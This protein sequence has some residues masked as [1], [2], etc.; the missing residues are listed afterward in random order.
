MRTSSRPV[1]LLL[2]EEVELLDVAGPAQA[3][4]LAG[5]Q[6]NWRPFKLF[7]VSAAPG[8]ISTRGQIDILAGVAFADCPDPEIIIVPGGYG[9][10]RALDDEMLVEWLREKGAQADL[11]A[12]VG[13]GALLLGKAGLLGDTEVS[14]PADAVELV[15]ELAPEARPD[16][17]RT[18][19][20]SGKIISARGGGAAIQLGLGIV[21]RSLGPKQVSI[22][23]DQLAI[24][25][26]AAQPVRMRIDIPES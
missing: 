16:P 9:A 11:L 19:I 20:D 26:E 10:R 7:A 8:P 14:V 13:Y 17:S 25:W 4:S 21:G 5:R 3:L 15:N 24:E 18:L 2:F 12:C 23:A 6:W 1:A 22:V